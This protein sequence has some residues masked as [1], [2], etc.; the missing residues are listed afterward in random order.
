M[1]RERALSVHNLAFLEGLYEAY[2]RDPASVP[3]EW[4]PL[5]YPDGDYNT[6]SLRAPAPSPSNAGRS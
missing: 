5:L 1:D 4:L 6:A 2:Q 3:S